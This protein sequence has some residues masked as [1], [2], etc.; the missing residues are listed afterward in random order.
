MEVTLRIF[1]PVTSAD[2]M[3]AEAK[4]DDS[5][6]TLQDMIRK[7]H[8]LP[9]CFSPGE[10]WQYGWS[11]D[12]LG[13]LVEVLSG[14]PLE[15]FLREHIFTPLRMTDTDFFVLPEKQARFASAHARSKQGTLIVTDTPTASKWS[16]KP[17]FLEGGGGLVSTASDYFRFSQM[18]LNRGE[19]DGVRLLSPTTVDFMTVNHLPGRTM[20][21]M[22]GSADWDWM[23]TGWGFGLGF[24]VLLDPVAAGTTASRGS[25]GWFGVYDTFFLVD[26]KQDLVG[27]FLA[28][29]T[30]PPVYPAAREFQTL[31]LQ[32][33]V[34]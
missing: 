30:P 34:R 16:Q 2:R 19:L 31:M 33:I 22:W 27:I 8:D 5:S 12:V 18:L 3:Y 10:K 7:L 25:F 1:L 13:Y 17:T 11:V 14:Q 26:P 23:L 15:V 32:A 9:L 20:P 4:L 28:Q 29:V 21:I 24:R 6:G